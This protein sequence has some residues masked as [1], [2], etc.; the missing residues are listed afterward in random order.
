MEHD[1]WTIGCLLK[2]TADYLKQNGSTSARLDAEVLLA[3]AHHCR[4]IDLYTQ[5]EEVAGEQT[6]VAYRELVR[7]RA[8]GIPVAYL[9]GCREFYSH[10]FHVT[11]DVLIPR[12]ETEFVLVALLDLVKQLDTSDRDIRI[13][14]VGT[15]SGVLAVCAA[16][17]IP[18]SQVTAIDI[19]P[20][21]L[22]VA[23]YNANLHN[24]N[25]R[26]KW[27]NGD[28]LSEITKGQ[29]FDF[30]ISNPP[31]VS[32]SEWLQL[33]TDIR[34]HEPRT[35]LVAGDQGTEII[36]RLATQASQHL[37][38]GGWLIMEVSPMIVDSVVT[39]IRELGQYE[40]PE[41]VKDLS[42][43][44]RVVVARRLLPILS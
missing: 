19:S 5:F 39:H 27:V 34:D 25:E 37:E 8:E 14:D 16:L 21:A 1:Q 12:P 13:A 33:A 20:A 28:L 43:H 29:L 22:D 7:R 44:P 3:E 30:V 42:H 26:L 10:D 24:V 38:P 2:W 40:L 6:R 23:R 4:R 17:H 31:Y 36:S 18:K 15:G 41:I 11:P 9:V 35:A 32:E